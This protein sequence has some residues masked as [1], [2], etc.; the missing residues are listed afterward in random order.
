MLIEAILLG[1]AAGAACYLLGSAASGRSGEAIDI[2]IGSHRLSV[3]AARGTV[4]ES[5]PTVSTKGE[6]V[7]SSEPGQLEAAE[8]KNNGTRKVKP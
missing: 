8:L 2:E 6:P 7:E 3:S 1:A 5:E 4:P